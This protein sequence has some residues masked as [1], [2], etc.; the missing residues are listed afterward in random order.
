MIISPPPI[1]VQEEIV[2]Y[3]HFLLFWF[4]YGV[5]VAVMKVQAAKSLYLIHSNMAIA[6]STQSILTGT[7]RKF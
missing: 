1:L 4:Y 7:R 3:V 2:L 6:S 5:Q